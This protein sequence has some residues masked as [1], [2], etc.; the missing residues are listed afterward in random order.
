MRRWAP[1]LLYSHGLEDA[2]LESQVLDVAPAVFF[3]HSYYGTCISGAKTWQFPVV[4]PCTRH[5]GPPCLLHFYPH[6]CGGL[7]PVTMVRDYGRQATRL[8]LL[9]RY[10]AVVT[11]SRHMRDEYLR[12]QL[13][14]V[15]ALTFP[16]T[17]TGSGVGNRPPSE[18]LALAFVGRMDRLKGGDLLLEALPV[19]RRTLNRPL[20]VVFA[21]D[22]PELNAWRSE[23]ARLVKGDPGLG[24]QFPGWLTRAGID[25]LLDHSDLLVLP[26]VWPEPFGLV[27]LEAGLR[28]VPTAAFAT[29]GIP[30]WLTDG[31]NGFTAAGER[32]A[33]AG[34]AGAIVRCLR[35][36]EIHG[37]LRKGAAQVAQRFTMATHLRELLPV[38]ARTT[39]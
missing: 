25:D 19:V 16:V 5:F 33:P 32:P 17:A 36:P 2:R 30:D 6:R 22:G 15:E 39:A 27:G 3:A 31:V 12:H 34:L 20:H 21:G 37:R 4:R 1:D 9:R 24:I 38:F 14:R 29:G 35:D 28:G 11:H 10:A 18:S 26:S 23:A 8:G 7:N 13:S